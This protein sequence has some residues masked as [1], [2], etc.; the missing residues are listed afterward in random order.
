MEIVCEVEMFEDS[1]FGAVFLGYSYKRVP[2]HT[3]P[4]T[5]SRVE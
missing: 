5:N 1:V 4:M 3:S 2:T